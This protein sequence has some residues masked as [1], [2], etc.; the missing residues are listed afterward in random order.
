MTAPRFASPLIEEFAERSAQATAADQCR[1]LFYNGALNA[2]RQLAGPEAAERCRAAGGEKKPVDFFNYAVTGFQRLCLQAIQELGPKL[3]SGEAVLQLLGKQAVDDFLASTA[4]KTLL[5]LANTD[6]KRMI[7]N[8]PSGFRACVTYG[9]RSVVWQGPKRCTFTMK[10][11]YMP[12][13]YHEGI[14]TT[15][16]LT[17]GAKNVKVQGKRTGVVDAD[18]DMSWE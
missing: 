11:D 17:L 4:G 14:L 12:H 6:P 9:E 3:G 10:R 18:Y 5:M 2:V 15:V 13:P 1:G 7:S 16:L 8:L